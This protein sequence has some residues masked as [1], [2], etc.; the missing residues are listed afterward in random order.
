MVW[1]SP[2]ALVGLVL[3]PMLQLLSW[4]HREMK[5]NLPTQSPSLAVFAP[6][7][8]A[9]IDRT[10]NRSFHSLVGLSALKLFNHACRSTSLAASVSP[11]PEDFSHLPDLSFLI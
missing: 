6:L 10:I 9:S 11:A 8:G 7:V 2:Q 4:G 1:S 3:F 5:N